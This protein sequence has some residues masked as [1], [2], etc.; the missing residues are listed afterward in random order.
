[1][2]PTFSSQSSSSFSH[3]LLSHTHFSGPIDYFDQGGLEFNCIGSGFEH[4]IRPGGELFRPEDDSHEEF[5]A[6]FGTRSEPRHPEARFAR[7]LM[8][9]RSGLKPLKSGR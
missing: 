2:P 4:D 6:L 3:G 8:I 5:G 7:Q 1:M 9:N